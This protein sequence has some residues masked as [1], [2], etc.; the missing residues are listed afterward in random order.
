MI[1]QMIYYSI[2]LSILLPSIT[3]AEEKNPIPASSRQMILVLT[4]SLTATT[5]SLFYF[6]RD[7]TDFDW[8]AA[9][10]KIQIV[11]GRNGLGWGIGWHDVHTVPNIPTKKEGDGRS[12]AGVFSLSAVFGYNP[13]DQMTDLKMPYIH[14][15]ELIEC[16]DDANSRYYNHIIS[17]AEAAEIDWGSSE[18]MSRAGIYYELGVV[19]D[20]NRNPVKEG[21]GSCIFLHNWKTPNETSAGCTE[22]SPEN[23]RE[24]VHWLD[25]AKN[26]ILVQLTK[27]LYYDLREQWELPAIYLK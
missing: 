20:H 27:Q 25:Q 16:I 15:T 21:A 18:K 26:P 24:I 17:R 11:L 3:F 13:A 14:V 19:V 12:P 6:E 4:D 5:G 1:K 9:G 8:T 23:M 7:C 10:D 2:M 22:M